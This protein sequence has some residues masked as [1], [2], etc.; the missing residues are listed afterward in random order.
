MSARLKEK[1]GAAW[2]CGPGYA[3]PRRAER[4]VWMAQTGT[5]KARAQAD[6]PQ[7]EEPAR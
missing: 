3:A 4:N 1:P 2:S 7:F 6:A 5:G